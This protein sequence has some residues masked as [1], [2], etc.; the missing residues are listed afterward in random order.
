MLRSFVIEANN[1]YSLKMFFIVIYI[2]SYD[3]FDYS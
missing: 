3:A 2:Y 1:V